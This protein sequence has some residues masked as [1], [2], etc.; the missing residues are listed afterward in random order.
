MATVFILLPWS[1][2]HKLDQFA[3]AQAFNS[4]AEARDSRG[5]Y[6]D[7][8]VEVD[9]EQAENVIRAFESLCRAAWSPNQTGE[10]RD[11]NARIIEQSDAL[12]ESV[13]A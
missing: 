11:Q 7:E 1:Q 4:W 9:R 5:S 8:V 3:Q 6:L 10:E 12:L 13:R 2:Y